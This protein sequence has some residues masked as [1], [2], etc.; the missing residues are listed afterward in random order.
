MYSN[1]ELTIIKI[2][3]M[4]EILNTNNISINIDTIIDNKNIKSDKSDAMRMRIVKNKNDKNTNK[5]VFRRTADYKSRNQPLKKGGGN[6]TP[7]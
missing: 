3:S 6:R 2:M 7:L 4:I 5:L 1:T